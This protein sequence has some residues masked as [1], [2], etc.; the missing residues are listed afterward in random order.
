MGRHVLKTILSLCNQF[1]FTYYS[2]QGIRTVEIMT[3]KIFEGFNYEDLPDC[4]TCGH[5]DLDGNRLKKEIL[6]EKGDGTFRVKLVLKD[7]MAGKDIA[8]YR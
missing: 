7:P 5:V 6:E 3:D 8:P 1:L 2:T 4:E